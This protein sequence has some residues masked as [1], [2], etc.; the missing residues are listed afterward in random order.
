METLTR[1][2]CRG[3]GEKKVNLYMDQHVLKITHLSTLS[4]V[5]TGS[6]PGI[7]KCMVVCF[8]LLQVNRDLS[9]PLPKEKSFFNA[10]KGHRAL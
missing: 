8:R 1:L 2:L 6:A 4:L 3:K 5:T 7:H 10:L 9:K